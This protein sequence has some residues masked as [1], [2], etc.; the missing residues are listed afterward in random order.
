MVRPAAMNPRVARLLRVGFYAYVAATFIHIAYVVNHEPF[1]FDAWNI[2]VDTGAKPPTLGRFFAFW[3][4]QYTTSN[5]RIGQPLAY[6]A[7][8]ITG[9]AEI[10]T[11]L[12]FFAIV[13]AGFV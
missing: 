9:I 1:A 12:A 3:H 8:K 6:L 2:S 10:G 4:Q 11:P 13:L 5:P 7:Y